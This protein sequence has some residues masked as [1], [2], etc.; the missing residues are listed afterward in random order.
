MKKETGIAIAI[1]VVMVALVLIVAGL[2]WPSAPDQPVAPDS[3][4]VEID[5]LK[6]NEVTADLPGRA[7][8]DS[9]PDE[10]DGSHDVTRIVII[11]PDGEEITDLLS[12][13]VIINDEVVDQ[14]NK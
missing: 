3:V 2:F 7:V 6:E 4:A 8:P 9:Y 14:E 10:D 1:G 5:G 12:E 13:K 11:D